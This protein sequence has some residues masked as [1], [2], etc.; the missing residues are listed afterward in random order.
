MTHGQANHHLTWVPYRVRMYG[1]AA[2]AGFT[3]HLQFRFGAVFFLQSRRR[4]TISLCDWSSDVCSSDLTETA[5]VWPR[6]LG[7]WSGAGIS[8]G[9]GLG[10]GRVPD[11]AQTCRPGRPGLVRGVL[12]ALC[13]RD[14]CLGDRKSVV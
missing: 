1:H 9:G 7:V 4:H 2:T 11:G 6:G 10:L 14:G 5:P 13:G 8:V 12:R 3:Y